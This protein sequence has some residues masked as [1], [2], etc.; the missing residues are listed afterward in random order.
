MLCSFLQRQS[1]GA[2]KQI[3]QIIADFK[4]LNQINACPWVFYGCIVLEF[5]VMS[6]NYPENT[7]Q[8]EV[9]LCPCISHQCKI[10]VPNLT[11]TGNSGILKSL[12]LATPEAYCQPKD[13]LLWPYSCLAVH[14]MHFRAW[15]WNTSLEPGFGPQDGVESVT[16][17]WKNT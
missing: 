11:H 12:L 1:R 16:E 8:S 6:D 13:D 2:N 14:C 5:S 4:Q 7:L 3:R 9:L 17:Q 10:G 15:N